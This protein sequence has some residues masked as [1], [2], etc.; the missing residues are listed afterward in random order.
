MSDPISLCVL[1]DSYIRQWQVEALENAIV[2]GDCEVK[3]VI[4]KQ[5]EDPEIDQET[6]AK[7]V[8]EPIGIDTVKLFIDLW[9]RERFW[10]L[11]LADRK[12]SEQFF[13][14]SKLD[15]RVAVNEV[16][17][18]R[19]ATVRQVE[20]ITDGD[21]NQLPLKTV[22]Q[23]ASSCDLVVRFGFGLL[24]GEI[25]TAPK[26]GVVSFHP[27]DIRRYRGLGPPQVYLDGR[28]TIGVTLQR[29]T[30]EID[31]GK[32]IAYEETQIA[33]TDTLWDVYRRVQD[34]QI[35]LLA[36]GIANLRDPAY[37]PT[38]PPELGSYYSTDSRR[39]LSFAGR[40]LL[41]NAIRRIR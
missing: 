11:V 28:N 14:A 24:R 20:S 16:T 1:A 36:K 22:K 39:R 12:L 31:G 13:S 5:P 6:A 25:L 35:D 32:I 34:L 27:A 7:A 37:E 40:I 19:T 23:V 4:I 26:W 33:P 18:F 21:W 29:L 8:N 15:D 17:C 3:L 2:N 38:V 41:K 9:R 30:E 10:T